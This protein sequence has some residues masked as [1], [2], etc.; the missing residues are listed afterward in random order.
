MPSLRVM[1]RALNRKI[2]RDCNLTGVIKKLKSTILIKVLNNTIS[3]FCYARVK[4]VYCSFYS[5][6]APKRNI[7]E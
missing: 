3:V 2:R 7:K 6:A 5:Q 4:F 1:N